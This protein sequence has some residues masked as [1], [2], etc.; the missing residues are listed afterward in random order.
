MLPSDACSNSKARLSSVSIEAELFLEL[1]R[2]FLGNLEV[3][4]SFEV[5]GVFV[6]VFGVEVFAEAEIFEILFRFGD[7]AVTWLKSIG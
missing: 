7:G 5:D 4:L 1:F 2:E 3:G 6:G